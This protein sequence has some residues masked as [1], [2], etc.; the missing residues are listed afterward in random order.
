M[1]RNEE[2]LYTISRMVVSQQWLNALTD[3]VVVTFQAAD[4][5]RMAGGR[6][7]RMVGMVTL[8]ALGI[9]GN[10]R[11]HI[12]ELSN[13]RPVHAQIIAPTETQQ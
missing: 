2:I 5:L 6:P 13:G 8:E 3:I 1:L 7:H 10:A 9:L 11:M 12:G 4:K